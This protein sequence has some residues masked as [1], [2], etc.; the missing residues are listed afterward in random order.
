MPISMA[1][2]ADD[3]FTQA[4]MLRAIDKR[5]YKPNMLDRIIGFEPVPVATDHVYLGMSNSTISLIRTTQRGA[6]I[7]VG[8]PD[9][10][11]LR[12]FK[13]PRIAKGRKLFAHELANLAPREGEGDV[14]A[15]ARRIARMQEQNIDDVELTE[16]YHRLG[17]LSGVLL[18]AN[19]SVIVNYFNEFGIVAP[20][21]I[22]LDLDVANQT[23]GSLREKIG[24]L[25]V[26]PIARASGAGNS[27]RF[28]INALCGDAFWF[29]LTGHPAIEQTY[30]NQAAA[31]DLRRETLWESFTFAGV[32]WWHYRG[33]DDGTTIAV[34][35]NKAKIFPVGVPGMFQHVM[36]PMN[37]S[38]DLM[39]QEGRRYYPFLEKDKSEKAQWVQPEI[40]AY[41]LFFN[42]RPDLVLTAAF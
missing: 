39:N 21:D 13:I 6:P 3:A 20:A 16:E 5:P 8:G 42:G 26:M 18:D 22:D 25:I 7:E 15:V 1:V 30:L 9:T 31:A 29:K 33:T 32:T 10:E 12:P 24:T 19:G 40:Y 28:A 14:S 38:L 37:E 23:I 17:A 11:N 36:G 27:P 35:T 34:A 4:S 41:P 2:F